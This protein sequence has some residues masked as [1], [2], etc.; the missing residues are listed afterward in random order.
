MERGPGEVKGS[1]LGRAEKGGELSTYLSQEPA[2]WKPGLLGSPLQWGSQRP[3]V[4]A[5]PPQPWQQHSFPLIGS[6]TELL[7]IT[8]FNRNAFQR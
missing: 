4:E 7:E 6:K 1:K 8:L 5:L 2:G 3:Q